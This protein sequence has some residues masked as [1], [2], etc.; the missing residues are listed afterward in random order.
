MKK[1]HLVSILTC[2]FCMPVFGASS[3]DEQWLEL[4]SRYLIEMPALS[5]VGATYMGDHRFDGELDQVSSEARI[6]EAHS[7]AVTRPK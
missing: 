4:T 6:N 1:I 5:P 7:F 3:A 2:I